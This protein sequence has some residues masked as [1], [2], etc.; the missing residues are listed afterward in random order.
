MIRN[1]T[2]SLDNELFLFLLNDLTAARWVLNTGTELPDQL[3]VD[4]F[5]EIHKTFL[6]RLGRQEKGTFTRV[7]IAHLAKTVRGWAQLYKRTLDLL[8]ARYPRLLTSRD[9]VIDG[10]NWSEELQISAGGLLVVDHS[11]RYA[12]YW[13]ERSIKT[14]DGY[15][16]LDHRL[17][18]AGS[19]IYDEY[20]RM[21]REEKLL[22][23]DSFSNGVTSYDMMVFLRESKCAPDSFLLSIENLG[24]RMERGNREAIDRVFD[25]FSLLKDR[26]LHV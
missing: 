25:L 20:A 12:E 6:R 14:R 19:Y 3:L 10:Y 21:V 8:R 24:W 13:A 9:L 18:F 17:S 1:A 22:I 5:M 7:P 16:S 2:Y 15:K 23:L 11:S 26:D 4:R